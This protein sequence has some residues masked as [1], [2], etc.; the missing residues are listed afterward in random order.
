[1]TLDRARELLKVQVNFG[2]AYNR[3][4]AK[5]ILD[6]VTREHGQKAADALILELELHKVFDFA[7]ENNP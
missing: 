1:M 6:E 7:V 4:A 2:G 5:L 3:H